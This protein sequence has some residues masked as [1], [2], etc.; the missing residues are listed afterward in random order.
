MDWSW[1]EYGCCGKVVDK[2]VEKPVGELWESLAEVV[3]KRVLH[4]FWRKSERF[5]LDSGKVLQGDLHMV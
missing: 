1:S 3:G 5:A 2:F 4:I